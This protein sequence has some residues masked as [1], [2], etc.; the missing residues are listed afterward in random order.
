VTQQGENADIKIVCE[1]RPDVA[2]IRL[3]TDLLRRTSTGQISVLIPSRDLIKST[4]LKKI[5]PHI[6]MLALN[7]EE[8]RAL[9]KAM[10]NE[11]NILTIPVQTVFITRGKQG[12]FLKVGNNVYTAPVQPIAH[13]RYVNGAGDAATAALLYALYI[14]RWTPQ[15]ALVLSMKIGRATLSLPTPYWTKK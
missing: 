12:A 7:E 1:I 5:L 6:T 8:A 2:Q 10:P 15:K 3:A 4:G 11:K 9:L 14:K 13:P